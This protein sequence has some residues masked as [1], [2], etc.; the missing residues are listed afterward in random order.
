MRVIAE[1]AILGLLN[2]VLGKLKSWNIVLD[3]ISWVDDIKL[4]PFEIYHD[5][6][7]G[8]ER[9]VI[10]PT[11]PGTIFV[12]S[13]GKHAD[14]T[15]F[16]AG[17]TFM[18]G[19]PTTNED[20]VSVIYFGNESPEDA[21]LRFVHEYLHAMNLPADDMQKYAPRFIPWYMRMFAQS[22]ENVYWQRKYYR[23]L[24]LQRDRGVM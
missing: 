5:T 24:L 21:E 13:Y 11:T 1:K 6:I 3:I 17:A 19:K 9:R 7:N 18:D 22:I 12:Y 8:V 23:W 20:R 16:F 10:A 15:I 4:A 14:D 2:P